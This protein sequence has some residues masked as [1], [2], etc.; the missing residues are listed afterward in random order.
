MQTTDAAL[1]IVNTRVFDASREEIFNA[2]TDGALLAQWWGPK[3]FTN[4]FEIFEPRPGGKWKFVMH[5]PNGKEYPNDSEFVEVTYPER[6]VINHCC[7][8]YFQVQAGFE[9]SAGKTKLTFRMLFQ[10]EEEYNNVKGYVPQ[11]NEQNF[12]RL[13][14]VLRK[15]KRIKP[16]PMTQ[17]TAYL[18]FNGNCRDAMNFYKDCFGGELSLMPV[19]GSPMEA[20]CPT[21]QHDQIMHASLAGDGFMLMASDMLSGGTYQP[22]NNFSLTVNCHSEE[23][24]H[25]LF[26]KLGEGGK[27]NMPLSEQFWGALFG[28]VTDS[29]GTR[30]ML[31][32]EKQKQA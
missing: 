6:I 22:G 10:H 3:G 4:T 12:D 1:E 11:A 14:A 2:W 18:N 15:N 24:I 23:Q 7:A 32:Y 28:T 25:S 9:D 29:F 19:K 20:R 5:G 31:N 13:E 27:V 21:A 26:S 8:P 16:T 17:I 30:W